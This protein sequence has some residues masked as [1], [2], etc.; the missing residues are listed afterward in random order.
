MFTQASLTDFERIRNFYWQLI[1]EM[2]DEA[3]VIGWKKGIY[4]EDSFL[5][6]SLARGNLYVLQE[7][8]RLIGA[9][10]VNSEYNEGYEGISWSREWKDEEILVPHALAITPGEQGKGIGKILI[11]DVI[12]LARKK[13]KKAVR[14][15]ILGGNIAAA[16][17]YESVG[18][19]F[20]EAKNMYYPDTG[21]ARYEMYELNL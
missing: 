10:I 13:N 8:E 4:P 6:D 15:D 14:L 19:N 7:E 11:N 21:W 2:Q 1:E 18:F 3:D 5:R 9:V 20:V 17:L 12:A 16:R